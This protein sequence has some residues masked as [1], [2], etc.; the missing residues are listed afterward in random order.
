MMHTAETVKRQ[1]A[2]HFGYAPALVLRAPGRINII[3]EHTDY[4][5]GLV[6]PGAIDREL[7]FAVGQNDNQLLRFR[8]LDTGKA[9][10]Q[11][12]TRLVPVEDL[13]VNYLLG[14]ADQF[15]KDGFDFLN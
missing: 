14:I 5:E 13:W 6:L 11:P 3:G 2:E 4:N 8:A 15:Q 10:D 1:F 7:Y 9:H 12:L